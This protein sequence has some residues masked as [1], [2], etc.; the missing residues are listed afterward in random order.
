M[1]ETLDY[2]I[3]IGSIPTF[4]YF[5]LYLYSAYAAHFVYIHMHICSH[6]ACTVQCTVSHA[7][8]VSYTGSIIL[9][10]ILLYSVLCFVFFLTE[11]NSKAPK[12]IIVYPKEI[13]IKVVLENTLTKELK[14]NIAPVVKE[15]RKKQNTRRTS[16]KYFKKTNLVSQE[17]CIKQNVID[18]VATTDGNSLLT[19]KYFIQKTKAGT[20]E[21]TSTDIENVEL[22]NLSAK[23][24]NSQKKVSCPEE[25]IAKDN[26]LI[27]A[28]HKDTLQQVN[29]SANNCFLKKEPSP[30]C[31]KVTLRVDQ[32]KLQSGNNKE[33][34]EQVNSSAD[35]NYFQ[36]KDLLPSLLKE[37]LKDNQH[38]LQSENNKENLEQVNSSTEKNNT[39]TGIQEKDLSPSLLKE[40]FKELNKPPSNCVENLEPV[41]LSATLKMNSF[42]EKDLSLPLLN[43]ACTEEDMLTSNCKENS[44]S[45]HLYTSKNLYSSLNSTGKNNI[46]A[47]VTE[48]DVSDSHSPG[49]CGN[50]SDILREE[51]MP[52]TLNAEAES[53]CSIYRFYTVMIAFYLL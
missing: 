38:Q 52:E 16:G 14:K 29:V 40:S 7:F 27:L 33:N 51:E 35:K 45:F 1:L 36:E 25:S 12:Q 6:W 37:T 31:P 22:V 9:H 10:M 19:A 24:I 34:L 43:E 42:C 18:G 15:K 48:M 17:N 23:K 47:N 46:L 11:V 8:T 3:R 20:E 2:T 49:K 32:Q 26:R 5:D 50:Y 53:K 30:L 4:L 28:D 21:L 39:S 44:D 13:E 41:T